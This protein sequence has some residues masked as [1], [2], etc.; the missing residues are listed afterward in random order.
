MQFL[1]IMAGYEEAA[2][3]GLLFNCAWQNGF[4]L[5]DGCYYLTDAG[6]AN[7]DLLLTLYYS[8]HYHSNEWKRGG[9]W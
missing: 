4:L 5:P 8:V 2:A 7:C 9:Q 1:Y 3:D 6:F